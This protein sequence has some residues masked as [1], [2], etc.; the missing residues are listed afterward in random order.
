MDTVI[1][2]ALIFLCVMVFIVGPMAMAYGGNLARLEDTVS[3]ADVLS[4]LAENLVR[5]SDVSATC[6]T[7]YNGQ[8]P[9]AFLEALREY[10]EVRESP[11]SN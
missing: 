7:Y 8:V 3:K 11:R 5:D 1:A 10:K 2:I 4:K 6:E 9:D